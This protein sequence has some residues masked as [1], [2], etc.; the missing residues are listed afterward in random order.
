MSREVVLSKHVHKL[1]IR[2]Q[3]GNTDREIKAISF[4]CSSAIA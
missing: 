2:S 3:I 1:G 4:S